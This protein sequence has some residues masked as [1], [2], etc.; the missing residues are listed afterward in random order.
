MT[1]LLALLLAVSSGDIDFHAW[2]PGFVLSR[3]TGVSLEH[4]GVRY[5]SAQWSTPEYTVP[6][7]AATE[8][9][10]SWNAQ[11][12]PGAWLQVE[13]RVNQTSRWYV[14]ARW[15][16]DDATLKR[17]TVPDQQDEHGSVNTDTFVAAKPVTSYR[18]RVTLLRPVGSSLKPKL[19]RVGVVA[20]ALPER[21]DVPASAPS[22]G[23]GVELVV[24][25]HSQSLHRGVH[26]ELSGGGE[27]W[28]SPTSTTMVLEYWGRG[29]R[30][31]DFKWVEP[32]LPDRQVVHAARQTFDYDYKGAGNWPFNTA[33]AAQFGLRGHITRLRDLSELERY[34]ARGIPLITSQSFLASELDGA[35]YG[36]AGHIMVVTGFTLDGDVIVNDP[37]G[38][39]NLA[40]RRVYKR[41]QFETVWLRTKRRAENGRVASGPGGTVYVIVPEGVQLP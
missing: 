12:P 7:S 9:I 10:V 16:A 11:T 15:S 33:Y 13:L 28:C 31:E 20:S 6:T 21:F 8:L 41:R 36:T 18:V 22:V 24:P 25:R 40:V 38:K 39:D 3:P 23:R 32:E 29:P 30:E 2:E 37:A 14:M 35:G 19:S 1:A 4:E 34:I 27:A 17:T 26:P 5:E